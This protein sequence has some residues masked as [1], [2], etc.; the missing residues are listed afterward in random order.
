M[1]S[2][3]LVALLVAVPVF[4]A[5]LPSAIA[6]PPQAQPRE[7]QGARQGR[8]G[9][10]QQ[11]EPDRQPEPGRA[12]PRPTEPTR[13]RDRDE[14]R[15]RPAP[16]PRVVPPSYYRTPRVYYFPPV[17][18][19][20]GFYYHP[21]F[22]FYYGP[23]YG[24][25]YPYPGPVFGPARYSAGAIRTRVRPVDTAV[26]VNGY[27]AGV[28]DDFDGIFQRLYLP[29]GGHTIEFRLDGHRTFVEKLYL[30]AGDTRD[31]TH[32]MAPLGP[33]DTID[34][35]VPLRPLAS[36]WRDVPSGATGDRPA[37]P[38][39]MLTLRIDPADAQ[40]LIDN[41]SWLG[42][43]DLTELV[44][45]IPAGWRQI[46]V[47]KEGY[48]PFRAEIEISEGASTRLNVRLSR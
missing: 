22:G 34:G 43:A 10:S 14:D 39:G 35:P 45:H 5:S 18:V 46:E 19:Q 24:P 1:I 26:Y 42:T 41:E 20:R 31:L 32:T 21:Y 15:R 37:S 16:P 36:E 3:H 2:K 29:A 40:V 12:Q 47:R 11:R 44:L 30:Q 7:P 33:G 23:Y 38:F 9:E 13:P 6:G 48:Q 17:S 27:Y 4:T 28:A 8:G 25:Y